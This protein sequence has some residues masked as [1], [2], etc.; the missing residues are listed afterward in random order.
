MKDFIDILIIFVIWFI[1][2]WVW[3]YIESNKFEYKNQVHKDFCLL[4]ES[5]WASEEYLVS[6]DCK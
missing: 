5:R 2:V 1:I 4:A 3:L 6:N